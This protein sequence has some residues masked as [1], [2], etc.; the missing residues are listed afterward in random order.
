MRRASPFSHFPPSGYYP[1]SSKYV[2]IDTSALPPTVGL[3]ENSDAGIKYDDITNDSTPIL[4]GLAEVGSTVRVTV[5][6]K[7]YITVTRLMLVGLW[8]SPASCREA[9]VTILYWWKKERITYM[10]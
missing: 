1:N 9:L 10:I 8:K 2:L 3:D 5:N 7:T 4:T 6:E